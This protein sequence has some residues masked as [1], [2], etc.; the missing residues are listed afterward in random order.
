MIGLIRLV[1]NY[2]PG[3]VWAAYLVL[4][5]IFLLIGLV[6]WTKRGSASL[7]AAAPNAHTLLTAEPG[8][9]HAGARRVVIIGSG[10][11]GLTGRDLHRPRQTFARS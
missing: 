4:G 8:P 1:N 5:G 6:L 3:D 2:L 11:A 9:P 7:H 10:P